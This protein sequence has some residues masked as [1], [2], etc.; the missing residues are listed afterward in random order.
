MEMADFRHI[1]DC[2]ILNN[3]NGWK[4]SLTKYD[5]NR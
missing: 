1:F 3:G 5:L 4:T 2:E